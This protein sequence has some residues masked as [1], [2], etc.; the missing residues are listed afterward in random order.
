ME[1][2]FLESELMEMLWSMGKADARD[3]YE[4]V[5]KKRKTTYSTISTTLVRLYEKG[6]LKREQTKSRGGF[7]YVYHPAKSKRE[8]EETRVKETLLTLFRK[9]EDTTISYLSETFEEDEKDLRELKKRLE[10]EMRND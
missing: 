9:F 1:I 2:G 8:F 10:E 6:L 3:V 4:A 7:K 5:R